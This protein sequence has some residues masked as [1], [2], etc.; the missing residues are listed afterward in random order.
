M[1]G[2]FIFCKF[3]KG[4]DVKEE[5][6]PAEPTGAGNN[7]Y[8]A[9]KGKKSEENKDEII[10]HRGSLLDPLVSGWLWG[11]FLLCLEAVIYIVFVFIMVRT[12][13]EGIEVSGANQ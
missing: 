6:C 8:K 10:N 9:W 1:V 7:S 5:E 12:V 3:Y 13:A 2:S 4:D 11:Y